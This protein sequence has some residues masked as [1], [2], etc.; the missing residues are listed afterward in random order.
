MSPNEFKGIRKKLEMTQE[1]IALFLGFAN[2]QTVKNIEAGMYKPGSLVVK[3][4]RYVDGL[5]DK[6][7]KAFV[8]E[9]NRHET[10]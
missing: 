10:E 7:R 4:L 1:Q 3:L 8:E 6:Q 2:K 9:F 5:A